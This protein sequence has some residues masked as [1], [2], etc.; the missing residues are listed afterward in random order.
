M[1]SSAKFKLVNL[2]HNKSELLVD[3]VMVKPIVGHVNLE[4][5]IIQET[6]GV[7]L[8]RFAWTEK[9][10]DS[11]TTCHMPASYS[12]E[13]AVRGPSRLMVS[14]TGYLSLGSGVTS[15]T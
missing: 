9:E 3:F 12:Y 8:I 10:K 5:G 11:P 1:T 15:S 7:G 6:N 14:T 4:T 13:R 2:Q